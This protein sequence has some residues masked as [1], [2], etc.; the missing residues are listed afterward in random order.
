M[1]LEGKPLRLTGVC[2]LLPCCLNDAISYP[3]WDKNGI[4]ASTQQELYC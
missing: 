3:Q 1:L 4:N 2:Q